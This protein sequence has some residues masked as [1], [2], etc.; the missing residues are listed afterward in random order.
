[1]QIKSA[2]KIHIF[3]EV[4]KRLIIF[5]IFLYFKR[6]CKRVLSYLVMT[7]LSRTN[8]ALITHLSRT[9]FRISNPVV[10]YT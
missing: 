2:A 8:N 3:V 7:H 6:G 5:C 9:N 4:C 1:M 10:L